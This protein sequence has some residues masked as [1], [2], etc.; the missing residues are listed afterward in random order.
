MLMCTDVLNSNE[1][2]L[3]SEA[4]EWVEPIKVVEF[5]VDLPD[6]DGEPLE[7]NWHRI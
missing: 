1:V 2:F 6:E 7:S 5:P 3:M 4:L